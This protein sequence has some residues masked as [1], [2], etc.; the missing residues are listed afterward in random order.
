MD[1]IKK[2]RKFSMKYCPDL[3][4]H[5]VVMTATQGGVQNQVCLSSHLC[6]TDSRVSCGHTTVEHVSSSDSLRGNMAGSVKSEENHF[7]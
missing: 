7:L 4:D 3:D 5:V 6:H 2:Q 1:T